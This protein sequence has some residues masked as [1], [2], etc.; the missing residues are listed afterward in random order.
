M[1][2]AQSEIAPS[3]ELG[4]HVMSSSQARRAERSVPHHVFLERVGNPDISVDRLTTLHPDV[5]TANAD[6]LAARRDRTF[7]GW[8]VVSA[9]AAARSERNVRASPTAEN[10][11]HADIVLPDL[12]VEKRDEQIRHARE[13]AD[14]SYWQRRD[15]THG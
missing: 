13:L 12:A 2:S 9:E 6:R 10:A 1:T 4:R 5:A 14:E 11:A 3:E 8:A 15:D 7:Y